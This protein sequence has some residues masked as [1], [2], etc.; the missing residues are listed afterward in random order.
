MVWNLCGW[1]CRPVF[2]FDGTV[3]AENYLGTVI[4][5]KGELENN[6][7]LQDIQYFQQDGVLPY[8][9]LQVGAFLND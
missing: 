7:E 3:N 4:D 9:Q 5:L 1:S 6:P 8:Y 2:F